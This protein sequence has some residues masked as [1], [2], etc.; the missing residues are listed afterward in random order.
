MD[1]LVGVGSIAVV[2]MLCDGLADEGA[3]VGFVLFGGAFFYIGKKDVA[4]GVCFLDVL[5][6]VVGFGDEGAVAEALLASADVAEGKAVVEVVGEC[7]GDVGGLVVYGDEFKA[8]ESASGKVHLSTLIVIVEGVSSA[9]AVVGFLMGDDVEGGLYVASGLV[10][11][12]TGSAGGGDFGI[13]GIVGHGL[14]VEGSDAS[15]SVG[16]AG[17]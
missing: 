11:R 10:G 1:V 9:D 16:N 5:E 3:G 8:E 6:G 13:D 15:M 2:G 4:V 14:I 12:G 17:E 7:A